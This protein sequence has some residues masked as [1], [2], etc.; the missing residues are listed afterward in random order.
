MT[1]AIVVTT[2]TLSS[3][4]AKGLVDELGGEVK[5]ARV[6]WTPM[7]INSK[8]RVVTIRQEYRLPHMP[9]INVPPVVMA[10]TVEAP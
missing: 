6:A 8:N 5:A 7:R 9:R 4:D 1:S 10:V 3:E 2:H